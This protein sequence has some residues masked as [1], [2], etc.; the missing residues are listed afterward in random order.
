ME[1]AADTFSATHQSRAV[2]N[3][4][5]VLAHLAV[6]AVVVSAFVL[7]PWPVE[8]KAL[9]VLHGLCA[10]QPGH[11]F[12]FGDARLPFDARMTGIYG[13]FMA[14]VTLLA[15]RGRWRHAGFPPLRIGLALLA[16]VALMGVD[17]LNS[18]L[19]DLGVWYLY[20]PHNAFRL[21]T[22]LLTGTTLAAFI[23]LMVA[24]LGFAQR[25]RSRRPALGTLS[26]LL[27]AIVV[28]GVFAGLVYSGAPL[29]RLPLTFVL[30]LSAVLVLT[31]L[32]LSFVLL[33][34]RSES[35][36][37]ATP[38]LA[39]PATIALVIAFL[40]IGAMSGGRFALETWLAIPAA[41]GV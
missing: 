6:W 20:E 18:T 21:A 27:V 26:D 24:Q 17:G 16:F 41:G 37:M 9:A 19:R 34:T 33:V 11:S 15:A 4:G 25:A 35:I 39:K 7:M 40:V 14:T 29:L 13:G 8:G 3:R 23:W 38:E 28:L 30:L 22:G 31:G 36:A 5:W 32:I 2:D 10:Q 12:Y 1:A